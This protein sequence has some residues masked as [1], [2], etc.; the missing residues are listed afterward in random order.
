MGLKLFDLKKKT[1]E[2]ILIKSIELTYIYIENLGKISA[3][4]GRRYFTNYAGKTS[5]IQL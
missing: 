2:A 1:A 4:K 3:K 5:K